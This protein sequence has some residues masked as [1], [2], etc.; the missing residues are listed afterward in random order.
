MWLFIVKLE[1][2]RKAKP[3]QHAVSKYI[4]MTLE[5]FFINVIW[6]VWVVWLLKKLMEWLT[7]ISVF[8]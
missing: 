6:G 1:G 4:Y 2:Y 5:V 3:I 8:E 7:I